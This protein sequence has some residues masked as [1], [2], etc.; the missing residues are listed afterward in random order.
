M[1]MTLQP[2]KRS[3]KRPGSRPGDYPS[4]RE[5]EFPNRVFSDLSGVV[6]TLEAGLAAGFG[7]QPGSEYLRLALDNWSQLVG[8]GKL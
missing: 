3:V 5:K 1:A 4:P 6:R 8:C 7:S 2:T